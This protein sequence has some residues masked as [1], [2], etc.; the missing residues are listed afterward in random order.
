MKNQRLLKLNSI[1]HSNMLLFCTALAFTFTIFGCHPAKIQLNYVLEEGDEF[2]QKT[3]TEQIVK[4]TFEGETQVVVNTV[5][6][7]ITYKV[8]EKTGD[9][10]T[11]DVSYDTLDLMVQLPDRKMHFSSQGPFYSQND[12]F[13]QVM[14]VMS[15]KRFQLKLN[16]NTGKV[17]AITGIGDLFEDVLQQ[18]K[19]ANGEQIASI[20]EMLNKSYGENAFKD[21]FEA[22]TAHFTQNNLSKGD[23]WNNKTRL[24]NVNGE[25][26]NHWILKEIGRQD[27]LVEGNSQLS[28]DSPKEITVEGVTTKL[29]LT[30]SQ[31]ASFRINPIKGWLLSGKINQSFKGT[32][33]L[34]DEA[35]GQTATLPIEMINSVIYSSIE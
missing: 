7:A 33:K 19:R 13:S 23:Q 27:A 30:G 17:I 32:M 6:S 12:L 29:D 1:R 18:F 2:R 11:F 5:T 34:Y 31:S 20:M 28:M 9:Q 10:I 21:A 26:N 3:I 22:T 15:G 8:I 25:L 4:Q 16:Y 35:S 14:N 24:S